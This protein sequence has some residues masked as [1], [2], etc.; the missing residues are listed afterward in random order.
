MD[1]TLKKI[2]AAYCQSGREQ[3][4]HYGPLIYR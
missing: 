1:E 2:R 3:P 4:P